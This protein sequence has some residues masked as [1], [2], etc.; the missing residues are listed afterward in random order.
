MRNVE[1]LYCQGIS[2]L[3]Y[4]KVKSLRNQQKSGAHHQGILSQ[5]GEILTEPGELYK[6]WIRGWIHYIETLYVN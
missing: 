2:D 5:T 3:L 4:D 6:R 1:Q